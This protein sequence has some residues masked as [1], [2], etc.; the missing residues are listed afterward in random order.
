MNIFH[1]GRTYVTIVTRPDKFTYSG[2]LTEMDDVAIY[3]NGLGFPRDDITSLEPN[4][5]V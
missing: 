4:D 5:E 3:V 1:I 2:L